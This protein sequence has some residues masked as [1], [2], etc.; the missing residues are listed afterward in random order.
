V[1]AIDR[2]FSFSAWD[3]GPE[4]GKTIHMRRDAAVTF[5]YDITDFTLVSYSPKNTIKSL[6]E[7]TS[8]W[9]DDVKNALLNSGNGSLGI[10]DQNFNNL[11]IEVYPIPTNNYIYVN[12]IIPI[13]NVH[14]Y[15]I[16][17]SSVYNSN[18][19]TKIYVA[20]LTTGMYHLKIILES[21][22][23]VFKKI[24]INK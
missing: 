2:G 7:D 12:S 17:G 22:S 19:N 18:Y 5:N 1:E 10:K 11:D 23:V 16:L 8:V 4:S 9:I 24:L 14:I 3:A 13:K 6:V 21:G 20:N 15:S